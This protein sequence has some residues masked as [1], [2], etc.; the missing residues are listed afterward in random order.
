MN[1]SAF[2]EGPIAG[3]EVRKLKKYDDQRGW[4]T[5]LYRSD[6]V[7]EAVVPAMCYASISRPGATRGPHEHVEQTDWFCFFGPSTFLLVLWDNRPSSPSYR[8]QMRLLV[9]EADPAAVIV[10]NG[11][12]HG[13]KNVGG[14]DGLVINLPN[15]LYMGPGRREAVDEIRHETDPASPF[16]MDE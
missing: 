4:L 10:P 6:E 7:S 11:V 14:C 12:V 3:V 13:Y 5:E 8:S 2:H 1:S 16:R 15:K 9:G